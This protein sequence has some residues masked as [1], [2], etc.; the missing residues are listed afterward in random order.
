LCRLRLI[1]EVLAVGRRIGRKVATAV[2]ASAGEIIAEG[3][4][5]I[6]QEAG[7][8]GRS[9]CGWPSFTDQRPLDKLEEAA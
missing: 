1:G 4:F 5:S 7:V 6:N 3:E 2:I 9:R 8:I